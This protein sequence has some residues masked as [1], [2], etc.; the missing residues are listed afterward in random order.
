MHTAGDEE[1]IAMQNKLCSIEKQEKLLEISSKIEVA[2]E[3]AKSSTENKLSQ[4]AKL[5]SAI[6]DQ[7]LQPTQ[8]EAA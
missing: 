6:L 8:S 1:G 2:C 7:E 3:I 5:K 4:L